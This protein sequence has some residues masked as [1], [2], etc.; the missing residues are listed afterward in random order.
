MKSHLD[1]QE[2]G[3]PMTREYQNYIDGEWCESESNRRFDNINPA[4]HSD[5]VGSFPKSTAKDVD[6]AVRAADA[7][8]LDW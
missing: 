7:A 6:R 5:V 1:L 3:S 4:D 8:Y 2:E